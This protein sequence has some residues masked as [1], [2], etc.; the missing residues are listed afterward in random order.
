MVGPSRGL[1]PT[2]G[3]PGT[4]QQVGRDRNRREGHGLGQGR[5][6]HCSGNST[7]YW[8]FWVREKLSQPELEQIASMP[9]LLEKL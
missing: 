7:A 2:L 1:T 6:T 4:W 5:D 9:A 8:I 3:P